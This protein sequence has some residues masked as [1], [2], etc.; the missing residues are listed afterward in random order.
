MAV[1]SEAALKIDHPV[2]AVGR[3]RLSF[4][5]DAADHGADQ[6]GTYTVTPRDQRLRP[7]KR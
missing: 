6:L 3:W 1:Q 2:A 5:R 4:S 7:R